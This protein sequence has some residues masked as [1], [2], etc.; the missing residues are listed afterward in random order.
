[1]I[2][3]D[4]IKKENIKDHDPNSLQIPIILLQYL[5]LTVQNLKKKVL[6]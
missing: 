4:D 2:C 6:H 5:S 3:F 1:M